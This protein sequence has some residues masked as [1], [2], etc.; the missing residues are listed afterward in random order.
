MTGW[1]QEMTVKM[2]KGKKCRWKDLF[3]GKWRETNLSKAESKWPQ[4]VN[5]PPPD[6]GSPGVFFSLPT[7][8]R[9]SGCQAPD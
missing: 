9:L 8:T 2:I 5:L 1:M 7:E 6:P 3:K 4:N